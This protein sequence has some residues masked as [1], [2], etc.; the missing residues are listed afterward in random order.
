MQEIK[1]RDFS[2]K[3]I[4]LTNKY[5]FCTQRKD[6]RLEECGP[7]GLQLGPDG[8]AFVGREKKREH[9]MQGNPQG[10]GQRAVQVKF[11]RPGRQCQM[12]P[13]WNI[14]G[15]NGCPICDFVCK[16]SPW[17]ADSSV[18][19]LDLSDG[20]PVPGAQ[21]TGNM[22]LEG[23]REEGRKAGRKKALKLKARREERK[24]GSKQGAY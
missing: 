23:G 20:S 13:V 15:W 12:H 22:I 2:P 3:N 7:S 8:Q 18:A 10:N 17:T 14:A 5:T 1:A 24:E 4:Q 16:D 21:Q 9:S 11:Y 19:E 6:S